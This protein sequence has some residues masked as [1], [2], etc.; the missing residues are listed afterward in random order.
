M[1]SSDLLPC[2][3]AAF[4]FDRRTPDWS[5]IGWMY[6]NQ[7]VGVRFR[8]HHGATDVDDASLD[9]TVDLEQRRPLAP[10]LSPPDA[11]GWRTATVPLSDLNA[12]GEPFHRFM[13]F[14]ASTTLQP[15]FLVDDVE[16]W[17]S[18][19]LDP[20]VLFRI[21][22]TDVR[23]DGFSLS[24]PADEHVQVEVTAEADRKSVV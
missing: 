22:P 1:C 13:L 3:Y 17:T 6:P 14:N 9:V 23:P 12:D 4:G 10:Y 2:A 8:F 24:V 5:W 11:Q 7:R 20:P 18:D 21:R 19:D 15:Q 16:L